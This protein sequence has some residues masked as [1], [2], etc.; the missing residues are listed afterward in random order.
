MEDLGQGRR[1]TAAAQALRAAFAGRRVFL[2]GH[3]GFKGGWLLTWL[4][5]LGAEVT[6][7]A[8][9]PE[10]GPSLFRDAKLEP[11][12]HHIEADLRDAGRLAAELARADPHVV[13]H[14]AAQSL[15]RRSYAQPLATAEVNVLGTAH[16]LEAV[17]R[18]G[19]PCAVVV[20]KDK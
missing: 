6:G 19:R 12:C 2:T 14:L 1:V 5:S 9:A 16:L 3:T 20:V 11:L 7:Y 15:V 18:R 13:F 17:R 10:P 4:H 8:L